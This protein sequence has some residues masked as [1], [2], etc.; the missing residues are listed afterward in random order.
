[1]EIV[2][3]N[4]GLSPSIYHFSASTTLKQR[5]RGTQAGLQDGG[6]ESRRRG[7]RRRRPRPR[8][9]RPPHRRLRRSHVQGGG[10]RGSDVASVAFVIVSYGALLLLLRFLREYELLAP[11]EAA[12]RR[13]GLRRRVWALCTLLT[14]MFAWKVASVM[15]WPG[16]AVGVWAAAVVTSAGGFVLLFRQQRRRL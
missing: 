13:E 1:M 3:T 16:V 7:R 15:T 9:S 8:G 6:S 5:S 4:S 11:P 12:V 2:S 14:L 10:G